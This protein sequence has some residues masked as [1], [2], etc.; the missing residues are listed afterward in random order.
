MTKAEVVEVLRQEAQHFTP[1]SV[2]NVAYRNA[3]DIVER[4]LD[5]D[6]IS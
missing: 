5:G 2:G 1:G 6:T 4:E 3:A